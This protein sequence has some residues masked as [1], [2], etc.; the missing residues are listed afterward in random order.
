MLYT[1]Y[2]KYK[3]TIQFLKS[4]YSFRTYTYINYPLDAIPINSNSQSPTLFHK[5]WNYNILLYF[6]QHIL[7]Q[8]IKK[9]NII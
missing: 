9:H 8:T 6:R 2:I 5:Y 4:S 7:D 3:I 1:Y